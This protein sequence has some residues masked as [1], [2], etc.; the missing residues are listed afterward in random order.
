MSLPIFIGL[1]MFLILPAFY[2]AMFYLTN[3][4][5]APVGDLADI[6]EEIIKTEE[7]EKNKYS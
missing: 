7:E 6:I 1:T 4:H 3:Q 2:L 5:L